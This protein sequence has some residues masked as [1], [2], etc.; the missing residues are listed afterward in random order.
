MHIAVRLI[1]DPFRG[2]DV[3]DE[4]EDEEYADDVIGLYLAFLP[5][6]TLEESYQ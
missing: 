3:S 6:H 1:R 2:H 4:D 5:Q